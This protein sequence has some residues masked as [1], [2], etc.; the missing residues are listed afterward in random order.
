MLALIA[1]GVGI[2]VVSERWGPTG[3]R[4]VIIGGIVVLGGAAVPITWVGA[5]L[6]LGRWSADQSLVALAVD[7]PLALAALLG[8]L[9]FAGTRRVV[10]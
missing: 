3:V 10:T 5:R 1:A 6:Y 4:G 9:A 2:S 7:L 8:A